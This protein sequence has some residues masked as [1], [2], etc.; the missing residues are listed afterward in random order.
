MFSQHVA[1]ALKASK[2]QVVHV[3]PSASVYKVMHHG[4]VL[5]DHRLVLLALNL[6]QARS[7]CG[8]GLQVFGGFVD[9]VQLFSLDAIFDVKPQL[10]RLLHE[11]M[12]E[13]KVVIWL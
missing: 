9:T 2:V 6:G 13:I 10:F 3:R 12:I 8:A 1:T 5:V 11:P 7:L 4:L